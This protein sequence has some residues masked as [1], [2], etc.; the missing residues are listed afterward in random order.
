[1]TPKASLVLRRC[2]RLPVLAHSM[3]QMLAVRFRIVV[4]LLRV[5]VGLSLLF[6]GQRSMIHA[7][8][9]FLLNLRCAMRF[10]ILRRSLGFVTLL[11]SSSM[12]AAELDSPV[13]MAVA[14]RPAKALLL[15]SS[16]STVE[17]PLGQVGLWN[18]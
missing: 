3:R 12:E 4:L 18:G 7:V 14:F 6:S 17:Y 1:M 15:H 11:Q 9:K 5:V 8:K 13:D 16:Q 10:W 2:R